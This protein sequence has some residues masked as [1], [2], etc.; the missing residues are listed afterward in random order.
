MQRLREDR[1]YHRQQWVKDMIRKSDAW[2][3]GAPQW[4]TA[5]WQRVGTDVGDFDP[6][7]QYESAKTQHRE[8]SLLTPP[9]TTNAWSEMEDDEQVE[10]NIISSL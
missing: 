4:T 1:L 6:A 8:G 7:S 9:C 3:T 5:R 10:K 2:C